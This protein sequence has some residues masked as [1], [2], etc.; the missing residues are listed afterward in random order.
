MENDLD[1]APCGFLSFTDGGSLLSVNQTLV[2]WLAFSKAEL[3]G[4]SIESILTLSSRIF[5]QTHFFPLM[6]LHS[7]AEEIFISFLSRDHRDIPMLLNAVRREEA[8]TFTNHVVCFPI[9]QRRK[10]EDEILNARRIAEQALKENKVLEDLTKELELRTQE[11]DKQYQKILTINQDHIQFNKI[12]SHDLQEPIHKI[13]VFSSMLSAEHENERLSDKKIK[14]IAKIVNATEH[15]KLLTAGLQAYINVESEKIYSEIHLNDVIRRAQ[16]KVI[17]QRNFDDFEV[18][19]DKVPSVEGFDL[20]L[21]LLFFQ[22]FDN[23]VKFRNPNQPL[24]IRIRS[25][26]INEN[27]FKATEKKY[28]FIEHVKIIFSDNGKGFENEYKNYVFTLLKKIDSP[29]KGMGM[30]LSFV[31]K[32]VLNHNGSVEVNSELNTGTDVTL[33]LPLKQ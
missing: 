9:Y 13:G 21:E 12:I 27:V 24:K 1:F 17:E 2:D 16:V 11:L 6:K 4:K 30:G 18:I 23:S 7:K 20:Q 33:I 32:I 3:I 15:L 31:K 19:A 8:G 29:S 14:A 25:V 10:Y 5:Y 26:V 22:L 28:K